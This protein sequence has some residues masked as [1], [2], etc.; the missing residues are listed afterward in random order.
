MEWLK[1]AEHVARNNDWDD[2]QKLRFFS[3]RL[4]GEALEWHGEY[5]EEQ[6]KELN[7]GDWRE[8]IIERFQDAFDL[9]T[10]KKK[11]LKL[12]QKPEENCRAFVSRLNS[13]YDSIEGKEDKLDQDK[14][15]I[16]EDH[17]LQQRTDTKPEGQIATNG[18]PDHHTQES[19]TNNAETAAENQLIRV[20]EKLV[21]QGAETAAHTEEITTTH[22]IS[23]KAQRQ[24][25]VSL[26]TQTDQDS[27]VYDHKTRARHT[28]RR[29][30]LT[31]NPTQFPYIK[32]NHNHPGKIKQTTFNQD[33]SN[34][35]TI[36]G[37]QEIWK[38]FA[39]SAKKRAYSERMLD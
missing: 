19:D 11:L 36:K 29:T 20:A 16:V 4:K 6:R 38:S 26:P 12:K 23:E 24:E 25:T 18:K 32:I 39:T 14:T 34:H 22:Q 15:T 3:D 9:A 7:Y 13:L 5:S 30:D 21:S 1:G 8:A 35:P 28:I 31:T 2:N 10:L 33:P 17:Y 37:H 27:I